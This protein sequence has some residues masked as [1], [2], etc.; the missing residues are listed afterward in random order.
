M[1]QYDIIIREYLEDQK[2][3]SFEKIGNLFFGDNK[4]QEDQSIPTGTLQFKHNKKATTSPGLI[5]FIS[6]RLNKN[7]G[8]IQS[9]L[10]SYIELI[11]Q[12]INIGKPYEMEGVG[13]FKLAKTNEYEFS[14]FDVSQKKEEQKNINRQHP[15]NNSLLSVKKK[16]NKGALML[17]AVLI[18]LAILGVI[19][20]GAYN[21][22]VSGSNTS[23]ITYS[24]S[25]SNTNAP[26][27]PSAIATTLLP[28][29]TMNALKNDPGIYK[30]IFE[31]TSSSARAYYRFAQLEKNLPPATIDSITTDSAKV[32]Q[33]YFK[34]KLNPADTSRVKD[35]LKKQLQRSIKIVPTK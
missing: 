30:F 2:S 17:F 4:T 18:V 25:E 6:N 15:E 31:T 33:L 19:G 7:R 24:A 5:D 23:G 35:S 32:Y 11:R 10:E 3:V 12:F 28:K 34:M 8:L 26:V 16:S 9:D 13:V 20:W 22:F 21:Y 29:D 14:L 27:D 1:N